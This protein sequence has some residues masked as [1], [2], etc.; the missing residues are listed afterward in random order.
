MGESGFFP[1][2]FYLLYFI[3]SYLT[4]SFRL[5]SRKEPMISGV[6]NFCVVHAVQVCINTYLNCVDEADV[7]R[8]QVDRCHRTTEERNLPQGNFEPV[9][10]TV[11]QLRVEEKTIHQERKKAP[12]GHILSKR[13]IP[14]KL[15]S[16]DRLPRRACGDWK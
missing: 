10:A 4:L 2:L 13:S 14:R 3:L 7:H 16:K 8:I 5:R 6:G 15:L 12:D 9:G 1:I 11:E